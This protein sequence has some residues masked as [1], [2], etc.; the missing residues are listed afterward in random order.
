MTASSGAAPFVLH[1]R[2]GQGSYGTVYRATPTSEFHSNG[3]G[4]IGGEGGIGGLGGLGAGSGSGE[5]LREAAIKVIEL[6]AVGDEIDE[7]Q[8]EIA[9]LSNAN[10]PQLISYVGSYVVGT[11]LWIAME[12]LSGGSLWQ[13]LAGD[14][15]FSSSYAAASGSGGDSSSGSGGLSEHTIRLVLRELLLA[16]RYL[17]A[18]RKI[19][20]DIKVSARSIEWEW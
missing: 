14:G 15:E 17:H 18:E 3:G 11:Q 12:Y 10:C 1:E 2:I 8:G 9:V 16:L 19:H 7:I 6:D 20:R 4:G 13:L 5:R